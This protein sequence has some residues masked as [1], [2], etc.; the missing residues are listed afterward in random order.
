MTDHTDLDQ[1]ETAVRA[2]L[3]KLGARPAGHAAADDEQPAPAPAVVIPPRPDYAPHVPVPAPR[4]G[5]GRLPDWWAKDKPQL[6]DE[7]APLA[8]AAE[9]PATDDQP[10]QEPAEQPAPRPQPRLRTVEKP[11]APDD[12][13]GEEDEEDPGDYDQPVEEKRRTKWVAR[14]RRPDRE[15]TRPP[16]G[17]AAPLY[18]QREKKSLAEL[19]REIPAHRK[20]LLYAGSGFA[21]GW[22]FH[23]PQFVRDATASVAQHGGPLR[24]NPDVYFWGV[25]AAVALSLD[26]ATRRSW[27]LIAWATRGLTVCFVVGALLYGNAIQT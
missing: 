9:E 11:A 15:P 12:E 21:A 13:L 25:A 16:F 20:W 18:Y 14:V 1:G 2:M 7:P 6:G 24:D 19:V 22:Y 26:R 4:R 27:F 23:I 5:S 10:D 3:R 8:P 17:T